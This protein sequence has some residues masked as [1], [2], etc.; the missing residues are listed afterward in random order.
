MWVAVAKFSEL[1]EGKGKAVIA[2]SK[3]VALFKRE[4]KIYALD[5]VCPHRGGPLG[6]GELDGDEIVCPWH[7]WGFDVKTGKCHTA[8]D[9]QQPMFKVKIQGN[10]ILV[11]A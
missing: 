11:D 6:E 2:N 7:A 9:I 4:G 8:S 1:E 10:D 5:N 3:E